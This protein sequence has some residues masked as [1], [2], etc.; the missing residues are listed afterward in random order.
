MGPDEL[1]IFFRRMVALGVPKASRR[2]FM[3]WWKESRSCIYYICLIID[4]PGHCHPKVLILLALL[5]SWMDDE[6]FVKKDFE[7]IEYFAGCGRIA[8]L[9]HYVGYQTAA[10][11]LDYGSFKASQCGRKN[12]LDLNS[13]AGFCLAIKLIL[14]SQFNQLIAI[15]VICCS[16]F[17]PVNR[18]TGQRDLLVAEGDENI[19]SVRKSN[20]LLSR[21]LV[22]CHDHTL[23]C[24]FPINHVQIIF[25]L[26]RYVS[27]GQWF[28]WYLRFV[29]GAQLLWRTQQIHW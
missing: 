22:A 27:Q 16:S 23:F 21:N 14:R 4:S 11:D 3:N 19:P 28:L 26:N 8:L 18:G 17:V 7:V 1:D 5:V 2:E 24:I 9:S 12:S 6:E 20:K 15:F 13:N 29:L 10:Y 25:V